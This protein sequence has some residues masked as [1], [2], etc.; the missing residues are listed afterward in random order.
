MCIWYKYVYIYTHKYVYIYTHKYV[1]IYTHKYVYVYKH[2][3]VYMYLLSRSFLAHS[4]SGVEF[5][6]EKHFGFDHHRF[7]W[8]QK[9]I[10]TVSVT[11]SVSLSRSLSLSL[12]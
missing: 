9:V 8:L 7:V 10:K 2:T 11:K 1:Y 3:Y 6:R 4:V 12:S 5:Y